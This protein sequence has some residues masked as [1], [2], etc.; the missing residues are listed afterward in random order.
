M[1]KYFKPY[2]TK[3]KECKWDE[4]KHVYSTKTSEGAVEEKYIKLRIV[5]DTGLACDEATVF[6]IVN[7]SIGDLC[8]ALHYFMDLRFV[9]CQVCFSTLCLST[10]VILLKYTKF[11]FGTLSTF[12]SHKILESGKD[13]K[14]R[15]WPQNLHLR[16][17]GGKTIASII[18]SGT[19]CFWWVG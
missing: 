19:I 17:Y 15:T 1:E 12:T 5:D 3:R 6:Q 4:G 7:D 11:V 2:F 18:L 16:N 8:R 14:E 9:R 10:S 13:T